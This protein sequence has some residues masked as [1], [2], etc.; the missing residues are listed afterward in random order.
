MYPQKQ[1]VT[2]FDAVTPVAVTSSTDATPIVVT[3]TAHGLLTGQRVLIFGHSTNIAANGIFKVGATTANTFALLD[4]FTGASVAG[5]GA[6]AGSGGVCMVAPPVLNTESFRNV[7]LQVDTSGTATLTL[8]PIASQGKSAQYQA[9]ANGP[10]Y[11]YPNMGATPTPAN[12]W[13]YVQLI[14]LDDGSAIT[15]SIGIALTATDIN[16]L[17]EVNINLLKYFTIIPT[18][19]TQGAITVKA[20]LSS[21]A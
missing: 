17:Y 14:A 3:A 18:A 8:K 4:E 1:E 9:Q 16:K 12:P 20:I 19:W 2:L 21:N 7:L 11:D 5:S 15:G 13:G 6:G 10:R